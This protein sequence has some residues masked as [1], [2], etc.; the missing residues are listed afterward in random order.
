MQQILTKMFLA[1]IA[2]V[3]F[4]AH[5][6]AAVEHPMLT[7]D[8]YERQ[9]QKH[10]TQGSWEP[11]HPDENMFKDYTV[12][13]I[14]GL[15]GLTEVRKIPSLR[16]ALQAE[17]V[18]SSSP[19]PGLPD[20]FDARQKFGSC[21]HSIRN[22]LKCGSCWAFGAA[23]TLTDNLCVAG[24]S[25]VPELSAQDLVSCDAKN[26]GC[27]GGD[28][29]DAWSYLAHTGI[30]SQDCLPYTAGNGTVDKCMPG[31]CA[32]G[33]DPTKFKCAQ[34]NSTGGG[35]GY[36][37]LGEA[38]DIKNGVYHM[39][40]AETGFTVYSDFMQYKSGVYMHDNTTSNFPLGG[41]AVKIIGWGTDPIAGDYYLVANSWGTSWGMDGYFKIAVKDTYSSFAIGGAFNCGNLP[42]TPTPPT[43]G[44]TPSKCEDLLPDCSKF[45]NM[46]SANH[47]ECK[48][49]CGC[50]DFD[51]PA[52]CKA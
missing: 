35:D 24:Q 36:N 20:M 37:M 50:C 44:P 52:Y 2:M 13:E 49:T 39:G 16:G 3:C 11:V 14:R 42:P 33:G 4:C 27:Q 17:G 8:M 7:S 32:S 10:Q 19:V 15:M 38:A 12:N 6:G 46:C 21:S 47:G 23:E 29:L 30:V 26:H 5:T 34:T 51:P 45:K 9:L 48:K 40:A 31:Q 1:A 25:D 43:P 41:H 22:Q 18:I 28:L